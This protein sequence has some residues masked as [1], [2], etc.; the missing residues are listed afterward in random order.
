[1]NVQSLKPGVRSDARPVN[2]F[3]DTLLY[4]PMHFL[5]VGLSEHGRDMGVHLPTSLL[6]RL[7]YKDVQQAHINATRVYLVT[8]N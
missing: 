5:R 1:M 3:N 4:W 7:G 6:Q 8:E 2:H